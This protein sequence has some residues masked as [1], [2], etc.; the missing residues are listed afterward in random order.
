MGLWLFYCDADDEAIEQACRAAADELKRRGVD[1]GRAQEAAYA[2]A[3]VEVE[4]E[5]A[6]T[7]DPEAVVAWYAA[8]DAAFRR[9]EVMTGEWPHQATLIYNDGD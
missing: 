8:E 5:H 4:S 1:A 3:E 9:L 7:P 2:A 6:G